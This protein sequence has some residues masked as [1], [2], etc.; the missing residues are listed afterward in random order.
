MQC[1]RRVLLID[2]PG[3]GADL[4]LDRNV[5]VARSYPQ[6]AALEV[7][8]TAFGGSF[9]SMLM[10]ALRVKSGLTYSVQRAFIAA[11]CRSNCHQFVH[12][13]RRVPRTLSKSRCETLSALK[14]RG[15][16]DAAI[17]S[18]A[19]YILGHIRSAS[20]PPPTGPRRSADLDL[21]HLPESYIDDFQPQLL[22]VDAAGARQVVA[23]AYPERRGRG[24][25]ADRDA[26][27]SVPRSRSSARG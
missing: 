22:R 26:R 24:H 11:P 3:F 1:A 13:D 27:A 4:L 8:N 7:T 21:Y 2:A 12:A 14:R 6:R 16:G 5:G 10:Q 17:D 20:R 19:E 9:G 15:I 18:A 25:R 23:N